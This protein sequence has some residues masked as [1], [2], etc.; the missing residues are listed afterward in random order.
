[1][2]SIVYLMTLLP[3]LCV[4]GLLAVAATLVAGQEPLQIDLESKVRL[5]TLRLRL[6][7][8]GGATD[9]PCDRLSTA[10]LE[11]RIGGE[12]LSREHFIDLDRTRRP[13]V[14]ALLVDNSGS[15]ADIMVRIRGAATRYAERIDWTQDSA[16][17]AQFS[18]GVVLA[19]PESRDVESFREALKLL[20]PEGQTSL[21]DGLVL[22]MLELDDR[23]ER[24][25]IVLVTDGADSGSLHERADVMSYA[26]ERPDLAV[27]VIGIGLPP[28][29]SHRGDLA[30][31]RKFLARLAFKT[32]GRFFNLATAHNL[33]PAF[34]AVR[35]LLDREAELTLRDPYPDEDPRPL[36]VRSTRVGCEIEMLFEVDEQ[37]RGSGSTTL[38]LNDHALPKLVDLR[39]RIPGYQVFEPCGSEVS[40]E[41]DR[42]TR[43][44][45]G[46]ALGVTMQT[47]VL[48]S[49]NNVEHLKENRWLKLSLRPFLVEVPS[50]AAMPRTVGQVLEHT[51]S[52]IPLSLPPT[53]PRKRPARD[54]GRPFHDIPTW[55]DGWSWFGERL[56]LS[57]QMASLPDL[58]RWLT[59]RLRV[60]AV[61]QRALL[62]RQF[63]QRFP[64]MPEKQ[65]AEI[66]DRSPEGLQL[67]QMPIHP[68]PMD[69]R[70]HVGAWLGD[71]PASTAL[72]S[73]EVVRFNA[74]R[75]VDPHFE[76]DWA[77]LRH[78]FFMPSYAHILVPRTPALDVERNKIGWWRIVLPRPAWIIERKKGR[79]H[80][81]GFEDLP[82]D[83]LHDQPWGFR[84]AVAASGRFPGCDLDTIDYLPLT[85]GR[86]LEPNRAF[87]RVQVTTTF[88][89]DGERHPIVA[90][91][92]RSKEDPNKMLLTSLQIDGVQL[93][94]EHT[95]LWANSLQ[96]SAPRTED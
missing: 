27:F 39:N 52:S 88:N 91:L 41:L 59:E 53:D 33:R 50:L 46:C 87:R 7:T 76:R 90:A 4:G 79:G 21:H 85:R 2:A 56:W 78:L 29:N 24:P 60:E 62:M 45:S 25:V 22:T 10:D 18:D 31:T 16:L 14:H 30:S 19:Q 37:R 38:D 67:G 49:S 28:I 93:D 35:S 83:L 74:R 1:M 43:T 92:E 58:R 26:A 15:V 71:I 44:I 68:R 3:R 32:G 12:P 47:G 40:I 42:S 6:L 73:W 36:R 86:F 20:R 65:L 82:V 80:R 64:D 77:L 89:C 34:S 51:L 70:R 48:Y 69:I 23:L 17:L 8:P 94:D 66:I 54:H 9:L 61:Q 13:V 11:V 81:P 63:R 55:T 96:P 95:D 5:R 72:R 75:G 57:E 84:L